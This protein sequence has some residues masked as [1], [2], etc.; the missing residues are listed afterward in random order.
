MTEDTRAYHY[1]IPSAHKVLSSR[2]VIFKQ[3][4]KEN[5][6]SVEV[7]PAQP[8]GEQ[9]SGGQQQPAAAEQ[10]QEK[11]PDPAPVPEETRR[12]PA[13]TSRPDYTAHLQG[14]TG[15]LPQ[16]SDPTSNTANTINTALV[17]LAAVAQKEPRNYAEAMASPK[18][19]KYV[20]AMIKEND[21]L[22][23]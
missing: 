18:A 19:D 17:T 5:L 16:R 4:S 14:K 23:D 6:T 11:I 8:E 9:K 20:G 7:H 21:Q 15:T 3:D 13:H 22:I 1:Y 10:P 2:N 12:Y